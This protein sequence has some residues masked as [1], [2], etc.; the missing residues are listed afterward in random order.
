[1]KACVVEVEVPMTEGKAA[2]MAATVAETM[3]VIKK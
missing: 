2:G 3:N 1:M